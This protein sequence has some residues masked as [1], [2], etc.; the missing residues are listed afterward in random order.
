[1]IKDIVV[2]LSV[3]ERA[4]PAEDY[5]ISVAAAFDAHVLLSHRSGRGRRL[6]PRRHLRFE[7]GRR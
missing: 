4:S 1:M 6:H 5:A 7:I 3:G 2:K